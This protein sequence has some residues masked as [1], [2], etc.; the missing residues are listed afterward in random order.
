MTAVCSAL[1][2]MTCPSLSVVSF[3]IIRLSNAG[4]EFGKHCDLP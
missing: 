4:S 1:K 2:N 3:S